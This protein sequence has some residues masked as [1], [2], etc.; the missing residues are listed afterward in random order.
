MLKTWMIHPPAKKDIYFGEDFGFGEHPY[1]SFGCGHASIHGDGGGN[2]IGQGD[3]ISW[4]NGHGDGWIRD[5]VDGQ[6]ERGSKAW[7]ELG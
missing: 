4:G 6:G 7:A 3:S 5:Y 1:G 2:G